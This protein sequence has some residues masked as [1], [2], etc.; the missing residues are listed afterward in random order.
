SAKRALWAAKRMSHIRARSM[1]A[2]VATPFTAAITGLSISSSLSGTFWMISVSSALRCSGVWSSQSAIS[3]TSPPLQ[4]AEPAPVTTM[5][6]TAS[7]AWQAS[8]ARVQ[9]RIISNVKAF[10]RSGLFRR[11]RPMPLSMESCRLSV[12]V[13]ASR[14][15]VAM[16]QPIEQILVEAKFVDKDRLC[17]FA[18]I[19]PRPPECRRRFRH[20][21]KHLGKPHQAKVPI[22]YFTYELG[23]PDMGVV[24]NLVDFIDRGECN[25]RLFRCLE[26]IG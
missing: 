25:I 4:N 18:E 14:E 26:N 9:A 19:L 1:P 11:M 15:C 12:T 20:L 5:T 2:P 7:S 10:R 21:E 3:I 22:R 16:A 8:S 6:L 17:G 23:C 13:R 24:K